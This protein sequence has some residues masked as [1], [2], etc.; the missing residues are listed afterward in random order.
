MH[1]HKAIIF[2]PIN[3]VSII[4]FGYIYYFTEGWSF[5]AFFLLITGFLLSLIFTVPKKKKIIRLTVWLSL[6]FLWIPLVLAM[7][8][9][10]YY[11]LG[12]DSL[13]RSYI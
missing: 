9:F 6:A 13:I 1:K 8:Q 2:L 4:L 5:Y 10:F 3:A 7:L 11:A 12:I